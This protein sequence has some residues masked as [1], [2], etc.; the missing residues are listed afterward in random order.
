[1]QNS[2]GTNYQ[3]THENGWIIITSPGHEQGTGD[4]FNPN[5]EAE[6]NEAKN[7]QILYKKRI[8]QVC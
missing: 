8:M 1:M 2:D 4:Y 3:Q 5:R 6:I 7:S